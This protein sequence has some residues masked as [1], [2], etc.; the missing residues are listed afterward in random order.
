MSEI[1]YTHEDLDLLDGY[2]EMIPGYPPVKKRN[3]TPVE[4][5]RTMSVDDRL[6]AMVYNWEETYGKHMSV[7]DMLFNPDVVLYEV[8]FEN[9]PLFMGKKGSIAHAIVKWRLLLGK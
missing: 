9:L 3:R 7:L 4:R 2:L 1:L 5:L 8:P 6:H